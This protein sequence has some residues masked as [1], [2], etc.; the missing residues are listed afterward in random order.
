MIKGKSKSSALFVFSIFLLVGVSISSCSYNYRL[1]RENA[2][3]VRTTDGIV[4]NVYKKSSQLLIPL[5]YNHLI[6]DSFPGFKDEKLTLE[7]I[8]LF[9]AVSYLISGTQSDRLYKLAEAEV[10]ILLSSNY[11]C[12]VRFVAHQIRSSVMLEKGLRRASSKAEI[13]SH[14]VCKGVQ[15]PPLVSGFQYYIS[16]LVRVRKAVIKQDFV[17]MLA[18]FQDMEVYSGQHWPIKLANVLGQL[19][20]GN[21]SAAK[22]N[23]ETL[24]NDSSLNN[25]LK[26]Q[27]NNRLQ[28]YFEKPKL[29]RKTRQ[30]NVDLFHLL[31]VADYNFKYTHISFYVL[32]WIAQK[33]GLKT[34]NL[35]GRN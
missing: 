14:E 19:S 18:I 34:N 23:Y 33:E 7:D 24:Q 30:L 20:E 22:Q 25:H 5:L 1:K 13:H 10:Q 2:K 12:N 15:S 31:M 6:S 32:K 21:I 16:G 27:M 17:G 3:Y 28:K 4:A 26:I 35:N 9:L 8:R 11:N 29:L